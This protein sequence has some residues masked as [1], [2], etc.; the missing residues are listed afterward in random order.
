[1][2][3]TQFNRERFYNAAST[4]KPYVREYLKKLKAKPVNFLDDSIHELHHQVF[5]DFECL[6]C[7][8]CCKTISPAL[9]N[10]DIEKISKHLKMKPSRFVTNYLNLDE[11]GDYVFKTTP[12]PFLMDDN[13]CAIYNVRPK[14]CKEY[15]HTDRK[16]FLQITALTLKNITVCPATIEIFD[17][18]MKRS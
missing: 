3:K 12:C 18:L 17:A 2:K 14:A 6:D 5:E 1:M 11:E 15:P 8:N 16:N 9:R 4:K 7:A 13:Y 10:K